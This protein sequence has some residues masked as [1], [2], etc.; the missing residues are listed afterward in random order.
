MLNNI[1]L[2]LLRSLHVLLKECHVTQ[3]ASRLNIS[4]SAV[5]RQLAQLRRLFSDPLLV[6][7]GNQLYLTPKAQVLKTKLDGLFSEFEHLLEEDT[8]EPLYWDGEFSFASSDYVAQYIFPKLL[9]NISIQSPKARFQYHMWQPEM[10]NDLANNDLHLAS[11]MLPKIPE[12]VSSC[13]LGQDKPVCVMSVNHP[14]ANQSQLELNDVLSYSHIV[15][16]G[17]SDKDISFDKELLTLGKKRNIGLR[18]PFFSAALNALTRSQYLLV[19]PEHIAKN[20]KSEYAITYRPLP[21]SLPIQK[22]WLIWHP[23]FDHDLAHK[24][25]RELTHKALCESEYSIGHNHSGYNHLGYN[26]KS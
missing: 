24:W 23:K 3:S 14:L 13:L 18:V 7:D 25:L 26:N 8:F 10:L 22:Y 20:L 1:N 12:G 4:Q 9:E 6:R 11:T 19:I 5:S 16:T 21:M 2:N 17:G 15:V